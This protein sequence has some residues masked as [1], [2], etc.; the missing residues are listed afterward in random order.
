M[1]AGHVIV[2]LDG[3]SC[4]CR[5][6]LSYRLF[7]PYG[8]QKAFRDENRAKPSVITQSAQKNL[9]ESLPI[10]INLECKQ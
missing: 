1:I 7:I 10:N 5:Q 4:I 3:Q 8:C 2:N 9:S 6:S